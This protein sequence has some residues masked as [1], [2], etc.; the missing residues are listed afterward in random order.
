MP[1]GALSDEAGQEGRGNRLGGIALDAGN[2]I[3][4]AKLGS[5]C[6]GHGIAFSLEELLKYWRQHCAARY[7]YPCGGQPTNV[8]HAVGPNVC[9]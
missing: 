8:H 3:I 1:F 4:V 6:L 7:S 5:G 2:E 9:G